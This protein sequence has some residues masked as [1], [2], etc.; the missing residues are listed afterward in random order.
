MK[1][2]RT[3]GCSLSDHAYALLAGRTPVDAGALRAQMK[4]LED[5]ECNVLIEL[6]EFQLGSVDILF[7]CT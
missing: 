3:A 4:L 6:R 7:Q 1:A 2:F 5:K